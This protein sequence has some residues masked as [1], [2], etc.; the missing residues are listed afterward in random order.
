[1]GRLEP[2]NGTWFFLF[3]GKVYRGMMRKQRMIQGH[4]QESLTL[5]GVG[6]GSAALLGS[7]GCRLGL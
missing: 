2:L 4:S 5:A 1:M 7:S 6:P 3:S